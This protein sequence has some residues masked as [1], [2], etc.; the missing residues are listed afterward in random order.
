MMASAETLG[1]KVGAGLRTAIRLRRKT[2]FRPE[3]FVKPPRVIPA[4]AGIQSE[5]PLQLT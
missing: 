2:Y 4:K 1:L 3:G 5:F